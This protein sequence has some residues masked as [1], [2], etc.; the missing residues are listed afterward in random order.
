VD[1][2]IN[3]GRLDQPPDAGVDPLLSVSQQL[4]DAVFDWWDTAPPIVYRT[5]SVPAAR[6]LAFSAA[7]GWQ[8]ITSRPLHDATSLLARLVTHHGFTVPDAWL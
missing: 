6:S 4:S 5:R 7:C 8:R 3:T 2:R 1:D